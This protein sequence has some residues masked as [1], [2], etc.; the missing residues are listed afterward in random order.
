MA[1]NKAFSRTFFE[2]I[3]T[4]IQITNKVTMEWTLSQVIGPIFEKNEKSYHITTKVLQPITK[5]LVALLED[6]NPQNLV[7]RPMLTKNAKRIPTM[8]AKREVQSKSTYRI[9]TSRSTCYYSGNQKF[10]FLKSR[11]LTCCIFFSSRKRIHVFIPRFSDV[12]LLK[13]EFLCWL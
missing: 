8:D 9:V 7:F 6:T 4:L 1:N 2:T 12:Q 3:S 10:C 11:L 13:T 5:L